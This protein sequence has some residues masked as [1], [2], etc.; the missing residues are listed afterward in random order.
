MVRHVMITPS[1]HGRIGGILCATGQGR[2]SILPMKPFTSVGT[3]RGHTGSGSGALSQL[4]EDGETT[5]HSMASAVWK[6]AGLRVDRVLSYRTSRRMTTE[7][8][9]RDPKKPRAPDRGLW[10]FDHLPR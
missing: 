10:A 1:G 4:I 9:G 6:I 3:I 5:T 2:Q 7:L 8:R